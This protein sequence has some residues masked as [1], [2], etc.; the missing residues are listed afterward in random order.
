MTTS[1]IKGL[2]LLPL[3]L[4]LVFMTG[5]VGC[6][7]QIP[8]GH[9]GVF[10]YKFGDGTEMGK[11]YTEGFSWHLPWNNIFVYK[12]QL[13]EQREDLHVLSSDGASIGLEMTIWFRP[14]VDKLDSLQL[15]VGPSYYD[16]AVAPALRGVSRSV[17]GK[18]KPE[19]IYSSKREVIS[20]EILAEMQTL[21]S[22][23][24]ITVENVIIRNVV[25]P[26][27]I[28]QAINAKLEA[29]QEAQKMEF[30]LLKEQQEAQ[31][32]RIEAQGISDFQKIVSSGLTTPLLTW[33]GIEATQKL[34]ESPNTKIVI[35]GK[36]DNGL[37]IILDTG[38]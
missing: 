9:R 38:K 22:Q 24:F 23:K 5:I 33:K 20:S 1:R 4:I 8:S 18:Y 37:P 10:Y 30:V 29:D 28:T 12:I 19:E 2:K 11:I 21:V 36:S 27:Q 13:G 16:I 14:L 6:G 32:K 15:T 31:R 17:V 7:T 26:D 3:L 25:L 34:A 35:I